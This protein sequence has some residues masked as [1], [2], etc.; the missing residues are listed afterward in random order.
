MSK[1]YIYAEFEITDAEAWAKYVPLAQAGLA[2]FRARYI[3]RGGDPEL[4]EGDHGDR[5]V[6]V[7]EFESRK[8]ARDWY[9]SPQYQAAKAV[10]HSAARVTVILFSSAG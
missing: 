10:R 9:Y 8:R 7:L 5:R 4:L 6:S 2:D 1:D 3:V